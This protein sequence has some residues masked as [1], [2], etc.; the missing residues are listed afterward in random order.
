VIDKPK[1]SVV[2]RASLRSIE[3][4]NT[5]DASQGRPFY[6]IACS[7]KILRTWNK[8]EVHKCL[9]EIAAARGVS[10]PDQQQQQKQQLHQPSLPPQQVASPQDGSPTAAA[11]GVTVSHV[12]L[13][14]PTEPSHVEH[15]EG[16]P[17]NTQSCH[18]QHEEEQ[19][20]SIN[21]P[22]PRPSSSQQRQKQLVP[23]T[24]DNPPSLALPVEKIAPAA[25]AG[26]FRNDDGNG[27]T[28]SLQQEKNGS[29][30]EEGRQHNQEQVEHQVEEEVVAEP[31]TQEMLN[32]ALHRLPQQVRFAWMQKAGIPPIP[33]AMLN[34]QEG[35]FPQ[36]PPPPPPPPPPQQQQQQQRQQPQ[37]R[38]G[39]THTQSLP[40][41]S[42]HEPGS[43][44]N[45]PSQPILDVNTNNDNGNKI[46]ARGVGD[47]VGLPPLMREGED[48]TGLTPVLGKRAAA[49][50]AA[51][52]AGGSVANI[53]ASDLLE[54][55][56][57]RLGFGTGDLLGNL[58]SPPAMQPTPEYLSSP[59]EPDM[60][61]L[62]FDIPAARAQQQQQMVVGEFIPNKAARNRQLESAL[63]LIASNL[64]KLRKR[65]G[66][67][68]H[69]AVITQEG[70][71]KDIISTAHVQGNHHHH[72][73]QQQQTQQVETLAPPPAKRARGR[74]RK[75]NNTNN[76]GSNTS[77][78][79][80][81][82]TS[83]VAPGTATA[84]TAT[85]TTTNNKNNIITLNTSI[86]ALAASE[87]DIGAVVTHLSTT[88]FGAYLAADEPWLRTPFPGRTTPNQM[89]QHQLVLAEDCGEEEDAVALVASLKASVSN[90][91]PSHSTGRAAAAAG[92]GA[93]N[94]DDVG[95]LIAAGQEG[96]IIV[97]PSSPNPVDPTALHIQS[98]WGVDQFTRENIHTL[99]GMCGPD[100]KG[101]NDG[102]TGSGEEK[103]YYNAVKNNFIDRHL[104]PAMNAIPTDQGWNM[105]VALR[106]IATHSTH[107]RRSK[108]N[109]AKV[110]EK[111]MVLL[112]QCEIDWTREQRGNIPCPPEDRLLFRVHP[113]GDGVVRLQKAGIPVGTFLGEY[114][115]EV[116]C[117][118]RWLE[119]EAARKQC[120]VGVGV[121]VGKNVASR[122]GG[123]MESM[124][125]GGARNSSVET[126]SVPLGDKAKNKKTRG[127][128]GRPRTSRLKF[129]IDA[130][131]D[132]AG[133]KNH[134]HQR[135]KNIVSPVGQQHQQGPSSSSSSRAA[136]II[137]LGATKE[138]YCSSLERPAEDPRGYDILFIDA[139][140]VCSPTS[141]LGHSCTP[142][143][144][145]VLMAIAGRLS[146]GVW[147]TRD[148]EYGEELTVDYDIVSDSEKE[149][150]M[151]SCLCGSA[152]CRGSLAS[153]SYIPDAN[154]WLKKRHTMLDRYAALLQADA[155]PHLTFDDSERLSK[156]GFKEALLGGSG[157]PGWL[158]K[159]VA[160]AL[161]V[162][163]MEQGMLP[164]ALL[165]SEDHVYDGDGSIDDAELL[166]AAAS[167]LLHARLT[168]LACTISRAKLFIRHQPYE[169]RQA[170][171]LTRLSD[172]EVVEFLWTGE[173]SVAK[174]GVAALMQY[175]EIEQ[176]KL[177]PPTAATTVVGDNRNAI[178]TN[179]ALTPIRRRR[180]L[181]KATSSTLQASRGCFDGPPWLQTLKKL[182][183][184][185]RS[186][187]DEDIK[188]TTAAEARASLKAMATKLKEQGNA[189]HAGLYD[190]LML[191]GST[192][193]WVLPCPGY[194]SFV[195]L[196]RNGQ[197]SGVLYPATFLLSITCGWLDEAIIT[198][199]AS[200]SGG[201]GD[202][203]ASCSL[204]I[205]DRR[206]S[207]TLPD[208]SC[209]YA[210]A[211]SSGKYVEEGER[212]ELLE[213]I[214]RRPGAAWHS[215]VS[216]KFKRSKVNRPVGSPQLDAILGGGA[217]VG[218]LQK[219]LQGL[220]DAF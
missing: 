118:W 211:F 187:I 177:P 174:S 144:R 20:P 22:P 132:Q 202:P 166:A 12:S 106:Y 21:P 64:S 114:A 76:V 138:F 188:V 214:A 47:M 183:A 173:D 86:A 219:L 98:T 2:G 175:I 49:A 37:I 56:L 120:N 136:R 146:L 39:L 42:I 93:L 212:F 61:Q 139:S 194:T 147:T 116:Y 16:Q 45:S 180:L 92:G 220:R 165:S 172:A 40:T 48:G 19:Q 67:N 18:Q 55:E 60:R 87:A 83:T 78:Q 3:G 176:S 129:E 170:P 204:S 195:P 62:N 24:I 113:K 88:N 36:P 160:L 111:L 72:Q 179:D 206:G 69:L 201:G 90:Q 207:A 43:E 31:P 117:P 30:E 54:E 74:P 197:L 121:G 41:L 10:S 52:A 38:S 101:S 185:L 14:S 122:G 200:S 29:R 91:T 13:P 168:S 65:C 53:T 105:S 148:V 135:E 124:S 112:E 71:R 26:A 119:K 35:L 196:L 32:L 58:F 8:D 9:V 123:V 115:G 97:L 46:G 133:K 158:K 213:A 51:A 162:V 134:Q 145:I 210:P 184:S 95:A 28:N 130:I 57:N 109:A 142:N 155:Q 189:V 73:Q 23:L 154:K 82:N 99:L 17:T 79:L 149:R 186:M 143:C 192:Q 103:E 205:A 107:S 59:G 128:G 163:E 84:T 6:E 178:G 104:L 50:A 190:V 208:P 96:N 68:Y 182:A 217:G 15:Q 157:V 70:E 209:C 216:F 7:E 203:A 33:L 125:D 1:V 193:H 199:N 161:E 27:T 4:T 110:A 75:N 140:Y 11:A 108:Y 152:D 191:Y 66:V 94:F 100:M 141:C 151:S 102:D 169:A 215:G 89:Q 156:Y 127:T 159:W 34:I 80:V 218:R 85:T 77:L 171:P 181:S 150:S 44:P 81:Q 5:T 164:Q 167:S 153:M 137:R 63:A 198:S 25:S 126:T 131:K